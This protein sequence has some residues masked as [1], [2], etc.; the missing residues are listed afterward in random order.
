[1]QMPDTPLSPSD[2]HFRGSE[3]PLSHRRWPSADS[4]SS[5][6]GS[7]HERCETTLEVEHPFKKRHCGTDDEAESSFCSDFISDFS[8]GPTASGASAT[9]TTLPEVASSLA[10]MSTSKRLESKQIASAVTSPTH[11]RVETRG[12]MRGLV[13]EALQN[14]HTLSQTREETDLGERIHVRST[15]SRGE[16][17]DRII[18]LEIAADVPRVIITEEQ[19]LQFAIQKLV[20]NAIKFTEQGTITITVN[21]SK[22]SE[23]VEIS[24]RDNGCGISEESKM[25]LFKPHFQEDASISRTRDGLGLSLFNAKAHVRRS[26]GGDVTLERSCTHGPLK[27]SEFLIRL[28]LSA[29]EQGESDTSVIGTPP[30]HGID[31]PRL[32]PF[33][34]P[35]MEPMSIRACNAL[36]LP[37]AKLSPRKRIAF[38]P[39]L[40]SEYPLR[41]LVAEDNA[42]NRNVAIGSLSKLGYDRANITLA[43][44]GLEA[45]K[46]YKASLQRPPAERFN[47]IL[48]DIWMP[49]LDGYE[50]TME[51][52]KL[53][54]LHNEP[55][56][57]I[58]VTADITQ[59]SVDRAK[60]SGMQ[61][62]LTKPYRVLDIEQLIVE[63]F[64]PNY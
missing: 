21:L 28:P 9:S 50:A 13:K 49:K 8:N 41:I 11:R 24:V 7:K 44:D 54:S 63:H 37:P 42:I 1:M 59:D 47:A 39:K 32:L 43:F 31:L 36:R 27:G 3:P 30:L 4:I 10:D 26:L 58:A 22:I 51:I 18:Q 25:N 14:G 2:I 38:N 56:S 35:T 29:L 16:I 64:S 15:G 53:A 45:V 12:F 61:G 55:V 17:Q 57:I 40:A 46:Q 33:L 20:D 5:F 52:I 6:A 19:H 60:A 34:D 48:M 62:F 23:G